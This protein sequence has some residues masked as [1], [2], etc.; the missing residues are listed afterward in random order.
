M[1]YAD[2]AA[3]L[4]TALRFGGDWPAPGIPPCYLRI[5]MPM[6]MVWNLGKA[7][8][9]RADHLPQMARE[10]A[11]RGWNTA[12]LKPTGSKSWASSTSDHSLSLFPT[13]RKELFVEC[14]PIPAG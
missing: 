2:V 10:R 4:Q 14:L 9:D 1:T 13:Y 3:H 5:K 11:F 8:A 7:A 6:F 12:M